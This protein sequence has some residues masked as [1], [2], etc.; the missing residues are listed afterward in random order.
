MENG[1]RTAMKDRLETTLKKIDGILNQSS[2]HPEFSTVLRRRMGKALLEEARGHSV[3]I[4]MPE[5]N[6]TAIDSFFG[7]TNGQI[8][9]STTLFHNT[10]RAEEYLNREGINLTSLSRQDQ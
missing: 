10:E 6:E 1:N 8:T 2:S 3:R 5:G 7:M 9:N 4:E